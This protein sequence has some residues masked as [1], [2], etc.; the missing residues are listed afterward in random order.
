MPPLICLVLDETLTGKVAIQMT[1]ATNTMQ[2]R[3]RTASR[4]R[5]LEASAESGEE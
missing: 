1:V 2:P 5:R 4:G 3:T